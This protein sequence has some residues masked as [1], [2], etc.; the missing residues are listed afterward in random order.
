MP[1][2][3]E[4]I[5][6]QH[7][8]FR[9]LF[10]ELDELT[11]ADADVVA[12]S[13]SP[14]RQLLDAHAEAEEEV[15]YPLLLQRDGAAADETADAVSDHNEIRDACGRADQH[16]PASSQWW[17]AVS[18]ARE[19]NSTHMAEEERGPLSDLRTAVSRAVREQAGERW[20]E[21]M[22]ARSGEL[23]ARSHDKDPQGYVAAH[24]GGS[25]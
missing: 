12:A 6:D 17:S 4:L 9:R 10:A 13:W 25:R 18:A 19:H 5:L 23:A 22:R 2:I 11:A 14:L 1:D 20:Q 21:L 16:E 8:H 7:H 15:L 3:C 24:G